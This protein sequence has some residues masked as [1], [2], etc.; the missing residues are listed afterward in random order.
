MTSFHSLESLACCS[1]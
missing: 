1:F